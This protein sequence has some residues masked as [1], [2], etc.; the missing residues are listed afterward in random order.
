MAT[1]SSKAKAGG[2]LE[3]NFGAD[4]QPEKQA[5]TRTTTSDDDRVKD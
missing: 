1:V 3:A 4:E 5:D 2:K